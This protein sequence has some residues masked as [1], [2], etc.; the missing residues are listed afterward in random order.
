MLSKACM[1]YDVGNEFYHK[2]IANALWI[3]FGDHGQKPLVRQIVEKS[4]TPIVMYDSAGPF[5]VHNLMDTHN[6]IMQGMGFFD[7]KPVSKYFPL[8]DNIGTESQFLSSQK[9]VRLSD[10]WGKQTVLASSSL[11]SPRYK[12]SNLV[13]IVRNKS[14]GAHFD[15]EVTELDRVFGE[16]AGPFEV[17]SNLSQTNVKQSRN[18]ETG[19]I[20][21]ALGAMIRQIG[22]EAIRSIEVNPLLFGSVNLNYYFP[23]P[24]DEL[25]QSHKKQCSVEI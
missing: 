4:T 7:G 16:T 18:I 25:I 20:N 13:Q 11:K 1:E 21:S 2:A 22:H 15:Y 3:L 9:F 24:F 12:R 19:S 10:W 6:L 14:G 23:K 5:N 8:Y 17:V